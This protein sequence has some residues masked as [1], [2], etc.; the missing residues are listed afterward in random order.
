MI[1]ISRWHPEECSLVTSSADKTAVTW[2]LG[3]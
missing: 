2:T 3:Q 1:D